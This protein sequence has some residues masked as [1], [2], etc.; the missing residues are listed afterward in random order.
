ME[1]QKIQAS[2]QEMNLDGWLFYD[3]HN[4]DAIAAR[5]LNINKNKFASRRWFYFIPA[6]G[7]PVKLVHR[8]ETAQLDHLPGDKLIYLPWQEQHAN[9]QKMLGSAK[10]V[11]MQYSPNNNIPYVSIVDGGT[12]EL[13]RSFG[14]EV[15]SSADLV[16]QFE[17]YLTEEDRLS[18][19]EAGDI[20]QMVK[21]EAF[22]EIAR[23]IKS[24]NN[25]TEYE[26]QKY[27]QNMMRTN[28]MTFMDGPIV[29][30]NEHA[31]DPHFEP[32]AENT[33]IMKEGDLVLIDLWAKLDRERSCYYDITWMGYIGTEVPEKIT[34]ILQIAFN[35]RDAAYNYV[36][37]KFAAGED[38]RGCDV[39]DVCRKVIVDAGYGHAFTHRTGHNIAEEVHGNGTHIDNLETMD[40]RFI[41]KG[42]CFSIEPGIYLKDEKIGFRTEIDVFI[43]D[44]GKAHVAGDVQREIIKIMNL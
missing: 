38:V 28:G 39:D 25:P 42:S 10:K 19:F 12:V 22:A 3:F 24:G 8:I 37:D 14:V 21:N 36:S 30:V 41:I 2:L 40:E 13:I 18:H 26:I 34:N 1:L 4:R 33:F 16:S 23:R 29:A 5:I 35:A 32:T 20:M 7:T 9:I 44:N 6:V 11:A 43:D 15:I 17:S 31:A 27:M